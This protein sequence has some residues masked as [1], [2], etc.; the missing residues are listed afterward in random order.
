MFFLCSL[1]LYHLNLLHVMFCSQALY[2]YGLGVPLFLT[3]DVL[4]DNEKW[5]FWLIRNLLFVGAYLFILILPHTKW[6]DRLP[7]KVTI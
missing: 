1:K 3:R 7:G 2:I 4:G 5:T 6:R